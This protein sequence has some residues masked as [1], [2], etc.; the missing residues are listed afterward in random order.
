MHKKDKKNKQLNFEFNKFNKWIS[1]Y[2][3]VFA[4]YLLF[5]IF[6]FKWKI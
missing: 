3:H 6:I 2:M 5:A 1:I 4:I